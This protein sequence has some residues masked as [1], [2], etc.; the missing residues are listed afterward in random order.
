VQVYGPQ[1]PQK[2][3]EVLTSGIPVTINSDDP[4]YFGAYLNSNYE[5]IASISHLGA[6]DLAQLA[7]N[8]FTASFISEDEKAAAHQQVDAVLEAW[9]AEQQQQ[10]QQQKQQQQQQQKKKQMLASR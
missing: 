5:Y 4:A 7:R 10:Q 3:C 9:K 1:L 2:L 6:D 8:S